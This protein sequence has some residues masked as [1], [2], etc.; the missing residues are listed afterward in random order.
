MGTGGSRSAEPGESAADSC[1]DGTG[2]RVAAPKEEEPSVW[3]SEGLS[4]P[5]QEASGLPN[6]AQDSKAFTMTL[7]SH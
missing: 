5:V 1:S 4:A 7:N 6:S 2:R 3:V